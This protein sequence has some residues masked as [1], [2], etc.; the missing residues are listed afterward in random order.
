M[1]SAVYH[2]S[3]QQYNTRQR[4][5]LTNQHLPKTGRFLLYC[6]SK[7]VSGN[8]YKQELIKEVCDETRLSERFIGEVLAAS[9]KVIQETL[10]AGEEVRL[11]GFGVFYTRQQ[12]AGKVKSIRTGKTVTVPARRVAAFRVGA[13]LKKAVLKTLK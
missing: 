5:P 7:E 9:L 4:T 11:P 3:S 8:V 6:F 12:P 1:L 13:D 2:F 10:K